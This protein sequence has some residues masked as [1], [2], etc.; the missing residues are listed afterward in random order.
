RIALPTA[1]RAGIIA[2]VPFPPALVLSGPPGV[3]KTTV[4]WRVFDRCIDL[5]LA[6]AFADLDL[7]GAA[8]PPP[9]DDPHQSRLKATNLA[10]IWSN[11]RAAGHRRLVIAGVV[12]TAA[13][14]HLL[15]AAVGGPVAICRLDASD[16][17]L[18]ERIR[19]RGRESGDSLDHL[20]R[21]ASELSVQLATD[22]ISDYTIST[23]DRTI[24]AVADE[25]IRRWIPES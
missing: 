2:R 8:W 16:F 4:G 23:A 14:R 3:G 21:R 12:E 19:H 1:G 25:V 10:V 24:D 22:D 20:V 9:A 7:L 18:A 11:Y 15:E 5:E 17:Q 6:P 13:E